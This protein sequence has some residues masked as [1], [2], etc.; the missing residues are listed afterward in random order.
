MKDLKEMVEKS[1]VFA[2]STKANKSGHVTHLFKKVNDS[3]VE[4]SLA[5]GKELRY[6]NYF[7][8][9]ETLTYWQ[10]KILDVNKEQVTLVG[11]NTKFA[12]YIRSI[13]RGEEI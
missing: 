3:Y 6:G 9:F 8:D 5:T 7:K 13:L 12:D 1:F 4:I 11:Y 2:E 10:W